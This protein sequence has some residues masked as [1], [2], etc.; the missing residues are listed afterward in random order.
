MS[1]KIIL[2]TS[3]I[4]IGYGPADH[5]PC[6]PYTPYTWKGI[7]E[8][9]YIPT[10]PWEHIE[11]PSGL[12]VHQHIHSPHIKGIIKCVDLADLLVALYETVID[13]YAHY[14]IGPS[15]MQE[16]YKI[17]YFVIVKYAQDG[18]AYYFNF[19]NVRID[20]VELEGTV[21]PK[22]SIWAVHFTAD[23]VDISTSL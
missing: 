6:N 2:R 1:S 12:M 10:S 8:D 22:E 7:K 5:N 4:L 13:N 19:G 9:S 21:V 15:P 20:Y 14:A 23:F 3:Y 11:I 17:G 18:T 16:K